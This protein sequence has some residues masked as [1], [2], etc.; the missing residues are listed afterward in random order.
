MKKVYGYT[1]AAGRD[2]SVEIRPGDFFGGQERDILVRLNVPAGAE[3]KSP[4]ASVNFD[5]QDVLN[6]GKDVNLSEALSYN[7]TADGE[8]VAA[9]EN[10]DVTARWISVENAGEYYRAAS[11]YESGNKSGPFPVSR[12]LIKE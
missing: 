8:K 3:G 6:N 10:R 11:A 7:V 2:G 5:Y 4:L 1:Y 9:N 12:R